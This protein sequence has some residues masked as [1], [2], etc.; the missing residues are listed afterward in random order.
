MLFF[1]FIQLLTEQCILQSINITKLIN[2]ILSVIRC[3]YNFVNISNRAKNFTHSAILLYVSIISSFTSG[4]YNLLI[5]FVNCPN[6][7]NITNKELVN[8]IYNIYKNNDN[9][10]LKHIHAHTN[11]KDIHSIGN[12][13]ADELANLAIGIL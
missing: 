7:K 5:I 11:K 2:T 6:K 9:L 4:S 1:N 3:L 10:M 8:K 12:A 13:K